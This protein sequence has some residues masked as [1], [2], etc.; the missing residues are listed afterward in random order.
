MNLKFNKVKNIK[1]PLILFFGIF[2]LTQYGNTQVV[3]D[4]EIQNNS[5]K[6]C[7]PISVTMNN[8]SS[9]S[10]GS[11]ALLTYSWSRDGVF[12]S[13]EQSP[14][15]N[16]LDGG[17]FEF[18]LT[19]SHPSLGEKT[20]CKNYN[21][22]DLPIIN[23]SSSPTFACDTF[24]PN[25]SITSSSRID[26]LALNFG[27]GVLETAIP[28][29]TS[30]NV[31][32]QYNADGKYSITTFV[33]DENGCNVTT[34]AQDLV[35][36]FKVDEIEIFASSF[37]SCQTT[38]PVTFSS[39]INNPDDYTFDWDFGDGNS[40][41]EA[42]PTHIYTTQGEYTV[43]LEA[44]ALS[45]SKKLELGKKIT[46]GTNTEINLAISDS[47]NC[48]FNTYLLSTDVEEERIQDILWDFG[49]GN[50]SDNITPEVNLTAGIHNISVTITE[51]SGCIIN[52]NISHTETPKVVHT[53][54]VVK[55][56][57]DTTCLSTPIEWVATST[58]PNAVFRW[59]FNGIVSFGNTLSHSAVTPR[60]YSPVLFVDYS[61]GCTEQVNVPRVLAYSFNIDFNSN[62]VDGCIPFTST[63][64]PIV[65]FSQELFNIKWDVNTDTY[66][67]INPNVNIADT[68]KRDVRLIAT[69]AEGCTDT[70]SKANYITPGYTVD[71]PISIPSGSFCVN[72]T[73]SFTVD[74]IVDPNSIFIW[75]FG[76]GNAGTGSLV[77]HKYQRAGKYEVGV[78]VQNF[79]CSF[80]KTAPDSLEILGPELSL[81]TT[82]DCNDNVVNFQSKIINASSFQWSI[83]GQA[84]VDTPQ[85][86][87]YQFPVDSSFLVTL[88]AFDNSTGCSNRQETTI[89]TSQNSDLSFSLSRTTGCINDTVFIDLDTA[90]I[91]SYSVIIPSSPITVDINYDNSVKPFLTFSAPIEFKNIQIIGFTKSGCSV[92]HQFNETIRIGQVLSTFDVISNPQCT[93]NELE[94]ISLTQS[95]FPIKSSFWTSEGDTIA[96]GLRDT[97][98]LFQNKVYGL[99]LLQ[100]D[101]LGCTGTQSLAFFNN[102]NTPTLD[103]EYEPI[104]CD[105]ALFQFQSNSISTLPIDHLWTFSNGETS[106]LP[107]PEIGFD[108]DGTYEVCLE[109]SNSANCVIKQC[110]SIFFGVEHPGFEATETF[111]S[112]ANTP[113]SPTFT[114]LDPLA[115]SSVWN[116]GDGGASSSQMSPINSF[117]R[118]GIYNVTLYSTNERG[119]VDT[120]SRE[121][122]IELQGPVASFTNLTPNGCLPLEATFEV[123]AQNVTNFNWDFGDGNGFQETQSNKTF[124]TSHL[125][126]VNGSF[127]PSLIITDSS[128]CE[129]EATIE[130]PVVIENKIPDLIF[131]E[132]GSKCLGSNNSDLIISARDSSIISNLIWEIPGADGISFENEGRVAAISYTQFGSYDIVVKT[133][134]TYCLDSIVHPNAVII[135]NLP[136]PEI[137]LNESL[138]CGTELR[139]L[140]DR[141][142]NT[143]SNKNKWVINDTDVYEGL[144]Q[145]N[146]TFT[147]Q[148]SGNI[149]LIVENDFGCVDT[150]EKQLEIFP[151][152]S[153]EIAEPDVVCKGEEITISPILNQQIPELELIWIEN[154]DTL[155]VADPFNLVYQAN[156][157]TVLTLVLNSSN[158]CSQRK[159][160][161]IKVHPDQAPEFSLNIPPSVCPNDVVALEVEPVFDGYTFEWES[162]NEDVSCKTCERTFIQPD[163]NSTYKITV[164]STNGCQVTENVNLNIVNPN[165]EIVAN[166]LV[167]CQNVATQ[168]NID[169]TLQDVNWF[170]AV[171][172]DCY[173]CLDPSFSTNINR[174][175]T[176]SATKNGCPV[177]DTINLIV[178]NNEEAFQLEDKSVC[179]QETI[180]IQNP[181]TNSVQWYVDDVLIN[182]GNTL[183]HQINNDSSIIKMLVT[184]D[185]CSFEQSATYK[186]NKQIELNVEDYSICRGDTVIANF[187]TNGIPQIEGITNFTTLPNGNGMTAY[188]FTIN[189][190]ESSSILVTAAEG[191][192][193]PI[194]NEIDIT[195]NDPIEIIPTFDDEYFNNRE[196]ILSFETDASQIVNASWKS[197]APLSC[198]D[199]LNTS[200]NPNEEDSI[201]LDLSIIDINGCQASASYGFSSVE[202]C[203]NLNIVAA[204]TFTPNGDGNNDL[205]IIRGDLEVI[206]IDIYDRWGIR[207]FSANGNVPW[208]G[209]IERKPASHGVYTY[210]VVS[211]C[212]YTNKEV[213]LSGDITLVR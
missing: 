198:D 95:P 141:S 85:N 167:V 162:N 111:K 194:T 48:S 20:T 207:V 181:I 212:P 172:I 31:S 49:D 161:N 123:T 126:E 30:F 130:N 62:Q 157:N 171:D 177:Q 61:T 23:I 154:N 125:Y 73:I 166:E 99:T 117:S 68:I 22:F 138:L 43:T 129:I 88:D 121:G 170:P 89:N 137:E 136:V 77:E 87:T 55:N 199:C 179:P 204:N 5:N 1:V 44:T 51:N 134:N 63:L 28:N 115:V 50:T 132:A 90:L 102:L 74:N 83:D 146:Y 107:N 25:I 206:S 80:E 59:N 32:H 36:L 182:S 9:H 16:L 103:Y 108:A 54:T 37:S 101:S 143:L 205:F 39:S 197:N 4:F 42:S 67:D 189:P 192:C 56:V 191:N 27:D 112:C 124:I 105:S 10:G 52:G 213:I 184:L 14:S 100:E 82:K 202:N 46:L 158:G 81:I 208:D 41:S 92:F 139:T 94:L 97:V 24:I 34:E 180:S 15:L 71:N 8:T 156:E 84:L 165:P 53:T 183:N 175:Y 196:K 11:T 2:F 187:Q 13:Q 45:C 190:T 153:I 6:D 147:D 188:S 178:A 163:A 142:Q 209:K 76:D 118:V 140:T 78:V 133:S 75:K 201:I 12:F 35:S 210:A 186:T 106:Q 104:S 29:S 60:F 33:V 86:F 145:I 155:N 26:S 174:T 64:E 193:T 91:G 148:H 19:T 176:V 152:I 66:S 200:V 96:S 57:P 69:N 203:R 127:S 40:S 17:N 119:C 7:A 93:Q 169:P 21:L 47:S 18:C 120:V 173:D 128:G 150:L 58:D 211:I 122:F 149:K 160:V 159:D 151:N 185:N 116:F 110:D 135:N 113:L 109:I 79:G 131:P 70:I 164:S 114:N 3:A 168:V 38:L 98:P 144:P 72:N 195:I 65:P